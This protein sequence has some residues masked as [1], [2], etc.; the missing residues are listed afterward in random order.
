[1]ALCGVS[2]LQ[3]KWK[4]PMEPHMVKKNGGMSREPGITFNEI[5]QLEL[6]ILLWESILCS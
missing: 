2:V 5:G 6:E 4:T 3:R 1:M